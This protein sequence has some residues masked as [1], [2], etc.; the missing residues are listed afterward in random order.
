MGRGFNLPHRQHEAVTKSRSYLKVLT[1]TPTRR[2]PARAAGLDRRNFQKPP[3]KY[4][5]RRGSTTVPDYRV[6]CSI[7]SAAKKRAGHDR[8]SRNRRLQRLG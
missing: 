1:R 4:D 7:I 6:R 5:L 2:S 8:E 3:R